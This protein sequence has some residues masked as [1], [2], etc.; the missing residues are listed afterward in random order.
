MNKQYNHR[1]YSAFGKIFIICMWP[2]KLTSEVKKEGPEGG[3]Y[4]HLPAQILTKSHPPTAQI[5]SSQCLSFSYLSP[6][7]I[8]YCL[9]VDESHSQCMKSHFP[10]QKRANP[11]S[12]FTL[13]GPSK[14]DWSINRHFWPVTAR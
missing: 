8:F 7:P 3:F 13:S 9:F 1:Y 6:I 5:P 4:S 11:N 14:N 12:H 2:V 10:S